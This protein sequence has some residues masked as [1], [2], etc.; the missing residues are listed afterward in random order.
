ML[1]DIYRDGRLNKSVWWPLMCIGIPVLVSIAE[2]IHSSIDWCRS[3][4]EEKPDLWRYAI[5]VENYSVPRFFL[6][7]TFLSGCGIIFTQLV[8][9]AEFD[10]PGMAVKVLISV[11]VSG[12]LV[13][14]LYFFWREIRETL[15]WSE[16]LY[17]STDFDVTED[18]KFG[19][20]GICRCCGPLQV[21]GEN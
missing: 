18:I 19:W 6:L 1:Q 7:A 15:S 5:E 17:K 8:V 4:G 21:S 9:C 12:T 14:G 2:F 20:A 16:K 10:T 13:T 3:R 11:I